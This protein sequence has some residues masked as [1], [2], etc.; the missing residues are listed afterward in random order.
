[1]H[2]NII[3]WQEGGEIVERY[4]LKSWG[5]SWESRFLFSYSKNQT[6]DTLNALFSSDEKETEETEAVKDDVVEDDKKITDE[7]TMKLIEELSNITNSKGQDAAAV[8][9]KTLTPDQQAKV[10]GTMG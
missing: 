8:F 4:L 5:K 6:E 3:W 2:C 10:L 1:M 7:E 9:F